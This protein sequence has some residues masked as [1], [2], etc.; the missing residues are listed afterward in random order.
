MIPLSWGF[1]KYVPPTQKVKGL[2][3]EIKVPTITSYRNQMNS[4]CERLEMDCNTLWMEI[5]QKHSFSNNFT[6]TVLTHHSSLP[7]MYTLV[8]THKIPADVDPSTLS[9]QEI[10]ARPIVSC[11][12]SPTEKLA[13]VV[14]N[15][16][17][18]LLKHVPCHLFNIHSNLEILRSIP[19]KELAGLKFYS[20]DIAALYTNLSIQYCVKAVIEMAEE[21]SNELDTFGITLVELHKL[22][23][24]VFM[25]SFFT[26]DTK[27][28]F[29]CDGLFMG[30]SPCPPAAIIAVYK[31]IRNSIYVDS[32]FISSYISHYYCSY[33]DDN[34][35]LGPDRSYAQQVWT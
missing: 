35:S 14:S 20:A 11:S 9:V 12:D 3:V 1:L 16:I 10:K 4:I 25:N 23:E 32:Y 28:Y 6:N 21:Y 30:C 2:S 19:S 33:V 13:W 31:M 15:C 18:P 27:L 26:F 7:T 5:S 22:L 24:L 29:Q 8:K 17:N 34:S